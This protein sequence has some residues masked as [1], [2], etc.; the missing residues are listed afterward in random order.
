MKAIV[1]TRYGPPDV[2]QLKEVAK[3]VPKDD[4][5]LVGQPAKRQ[6]VT[7]PENTVFSVKRLMGRRYDDAETLLLRIVE[8]RTR[9]DGR[10]HQ[11]TLGSLA[12]AYVVVVRPAWFREWTE[13]LYSD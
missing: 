10:R 8:V 12:A 2:L 6:A 11:H 13:K 3:P 4:E 7:N 9:V 5:V 1:W